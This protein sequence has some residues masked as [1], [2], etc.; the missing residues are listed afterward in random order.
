MWIIYIEHMC[1]SYSYISGTQVV[2]VLRSNISV[3]T[4]NRIT[5]NHKTKNR[6]MLMRLASVL[7]VWFVYQ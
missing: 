7:L 5:K 2:I 1:I 4:S 3:K 6:S